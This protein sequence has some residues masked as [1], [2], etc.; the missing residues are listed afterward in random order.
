MILKVSSEIEI[1]SLEITFEG[2]SSGTAHIRGKIHP[3]RTY[4]PN[5]TQFSMRVPLCEDFEHPVLQPLRDWLSR[6][7]GLQFEHQNE[8]AEDQ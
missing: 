7:V 5:N 2:L 3:L 6:E 8:K 4:G 1:E